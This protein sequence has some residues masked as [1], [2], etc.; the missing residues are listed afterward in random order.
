[1]KLSTLIE[2]IGLGAA[3]EA[4]LLVARL[5]DPGMIVATSEDTIAR[6][7]ARARHE[8][9]ALSG[10]GHAAAALGLELPAEG[11]GLARVEQLCASTRDGGVVIVCESQPLGGSLERARTAGLFLRAGLVELQQES[12]V[13][14]VFTTG[15]V[16]RRAVD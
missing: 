9:V 10:A 4:K 8:R 7:L 16:R 3:R 2:A 5:P 11:E 12:A 1:M 15:R 13:G 14:T 6:A